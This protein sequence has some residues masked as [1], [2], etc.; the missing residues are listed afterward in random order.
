MAVHPTDTKTISFRSMS[1]RNQDVDKRPSSVSSQSRIEP[2]T[3]NHNQKKIL[4]TNIQQTPINTSTTQ[5]MSP[6]L[7]KEEDRY[8]YGLS[9]QEVIATNQKAE[10]VLVTGFVPNPFWHSFQKSVAAVHNPDDEQ[11]IQCFENEL[12][13]PLKTFLIS[14]LPNCS[15]I[16]NV[17]HLGFGADKYANP[18]VIH[19]CIQTPHYFTNNKAAALKVVQGMEKIIKEKLDNQKYE[20]DIHE[21]F[22]IDIC[23]IYNSKSKTS[24]LESKDEVNKN[25]GTDLR[26]SNSTHFPGVILTENFPAVYLND[27][28]CPG[29]SIGR[30]ETEERIYPAG[31]LTGFLQ[32][33]N[34]LYSLTCSHV[35]FPDPERSSERYKYND[36]MEQF[37]ISIPAFKDHKA[38]LEAM[39]YKLKH[40]RIAI[41]K[42]EKRQVMCPEMDFSSRIQW[43][44]EEEIHCARQLKEAQD[45]SIHAGYVYAASEEWRKVVTFNGILDWALIRNACVDPRNQLPPFYLL[46]EPQ[47]L[48]FI[49]KFGDKYWSSDERKAFTTKCQALQ[50][51]IEFNV[52]HPR[53]FSLFNEKSIYFK[54]LSRT[55]GWKAC[56]LN[57]IQAIVHNQNS[58]SDERVFIGDD[59]QKAKEKISD[60]GDSGALIYSI[61]VDIEGN[62]VLVPMAM[63]WAGNTDGFE[64]FQGDVTY[65]T[66]IEEVLKDIESEMGWENGSLKFF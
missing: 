12:R 31:S 20:N 52:S 41:E 3:F 13:L 48:G 58:T 55:T 66:P 22:N 17:L 21:K 65:A 19:V 63:I 40:A 44:K 16:L 23:Q 38:T 43:N 33:E 51:S 47:V 26:S 6:W 9:E 10:D 64:G 5:N 15:W 49:E 18:I 39:K 61:D 14:S 11:Y 7:V 24:E 45:Y 53:S 32:Q 59:T 60:G 36:G 50:D 2:K 4:H 42:A 37:K 57:V 46:K 1:V 27:T 35:A 8:K 28:P 30:G 34:T 29:L 62:T 25:S 54:A 56:E